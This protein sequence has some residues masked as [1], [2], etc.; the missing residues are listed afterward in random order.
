M[1]EAQ[2]RAYVL[3]ALRQKSRFWKPAM[4]AKN[5]ACVGIKRNTIT[6]R[7]GKHYLCAECKS[8]TPSSLIKIDHIEP[9]VDPKVGFV[10]W[11]TLIDRLFSP[12]SNYQAVCKK[13]HDEK[14]KEERME[15]A[16]YKKLRKENNE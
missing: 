13:C 15:R 7:L 14:T 3:S 11:N 8:L 9:V 4:E 6:G 12:E 5:K 2:F 1:T 16:K 10:D